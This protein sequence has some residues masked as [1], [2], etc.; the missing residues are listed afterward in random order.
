MPEILL[1]VPSQVKFKPRQIQQ[2]YVNEHQRETLIAE[3]YTLVD[4][5]ACE[6]MAIE[7]E[8]VIDN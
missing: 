1:E 8:Y 5:F 6:G 3:G 7:T 4:P 2:Y